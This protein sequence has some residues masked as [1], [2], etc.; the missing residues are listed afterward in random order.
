MLPKKGHHWLAW[1][2]ACETPPRCYRLTEFRLLMQYVKRSSRN[3]KPQKHS[4]E[5]TRV[6]QEILPA[7]L[8]AVS[9]LALY[10]RLTGTQPARLQKPEIYLLLS[11]VAAAR[12]MRGPRLQPGVQTSISQPFRK[13]HFNGVA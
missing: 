6:C 13:P 4:T 9:A 5:Q 10:A 3:S 2:L 11:A 7:S 1:A 8:I 12:S